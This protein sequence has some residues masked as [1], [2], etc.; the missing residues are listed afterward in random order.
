MP[1]SQTD[2]KPVYVE[3]LPPGERPRLRGTGKL[4]DTVQGVG[5]ALLRLEHVEAVDKGILKFRIGGDETSGRP[6]DIRHWWPDW[7]PERPHPESDS[8]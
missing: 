7:W 8:S 1:N 5:L 4:L 2:I 6:W 3:N